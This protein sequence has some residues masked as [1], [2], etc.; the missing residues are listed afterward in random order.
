MPEPYVSRGGTVSPLP[1]PHAVE[2]E[3]ARQLARLLDQWRDK[4]PG[5]PVGQDVVQGHPGRALAGLSARAD[6][7][8]IGRHAKHPDLQGPGTVRHALLNHAHGTVAVV[9][10]S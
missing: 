6:L 8:V 10:S 1:H 4:Y 3:A 7:V 5:V 9:P 2:A